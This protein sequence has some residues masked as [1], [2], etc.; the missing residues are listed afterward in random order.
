MLPYLAKGIWQMRLS[1][2][3]TLNYLGGPNLITRV[4]KIREP[5]QLWAEEKHDMT[6]EGQR[7]G[8]MRRIP[9]L[10]SALR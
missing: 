2:E 9:H 4:Y 8:I 7:K 3:I 5:F 10:F 1:I 6:V